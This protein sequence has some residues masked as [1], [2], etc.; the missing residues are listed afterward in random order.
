MKRA[1]SILSVLA[2]AVLGGAA[3]AQPEPAPTGTLLPN[4]INVYPVGSTPPAYSSRVADIPL[5]DN[6]NYFNF[7]AIVAGVA[8]GNTNWA[9][10]FS[11]AGGPYAGATGRTIT[12]IGWVIY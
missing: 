11:F 8:A 7:S 12:G 10:D 3:F 5:V 4:V 6:T 1:G 9:D 2:A